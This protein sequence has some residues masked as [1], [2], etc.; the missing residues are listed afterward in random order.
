MTPV[1]STRYST[2][3]GLGLFD[4]GR[5]VKSDGAGFRVGHETAR[6]EH[7]T[8]FDRRDASCQ[9]LRSRRRS[10]STT[11]DPGDDVFATDDIS[12]GFFRFPN[13]VA[14]GVTR[15][16]FDLPR[17]CGNL[18]VPRTAGLLYA[19]RRRATLLT[20]RFSSNFAKAISLTF[21]I[22]VSRVYLRP[23]S[24][25]SEARRDTSFRASSFC[26]PEVLTD[27]RPPSMMSRI[28]QM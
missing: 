17:P 26:A 5:Y 21:V 13:L 3:T 1:L 6:A 22:A 12:P 11:L 18:I 14:L 4:C 24:I 15:T 16:V 25:F 2:H 19:D 20:Q 10:R 23:G 8:Q 28:S 9:A 7:L 27:L